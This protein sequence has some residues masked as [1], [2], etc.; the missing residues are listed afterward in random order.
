MTE[1]IIIV[2]NG[3]TTR[4]NV[5]A[6]I[7]DYFYANP[8]LTVYITVDSAI[9][10][11]QIWAA[12]YAVDKEITVVAY[13]TEGAKMTGLPLEATRENTPNPVLKACQAH[14]DAIGFLL[15]DDEDVDCLNA[16]AVLQD[17]GFEALDLTNGLVSIASAKPIEQVK[18]PEIPEQER[19][20]ET[21][22]E[23]VVEVSDEEDGYEDP[24]YE[25]VRMVA[26]IFAEE[27]AKKLAEVL[28][29]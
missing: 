24:L 22:P 15:W 27:L 26:E 17:S 19:I 11:G 16:L 20:V 13:M 9:S 10:E 25:A 18:A 1:A 5:E 7:D 12:Q 28:D 3:E 14:E 2:G 29:K 21:E 23:P 4:A 8:E 6:L